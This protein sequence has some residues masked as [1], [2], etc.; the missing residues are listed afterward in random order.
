MNRSNLFVVS[1]LVAGL[2]VPALVMAGG[3]NEQPMPSQ[4][5]ATDA[6]K[7][8]AATSSAAGTELLGAGASFPYPIYSKMFDEYNKATGVKVNYQSIGSSGGVKNIK[9]KVVDFGASDAFLNDEAMKQFDAP[10]V[11]IPTVLGSIVVTYNLPGNPTLK[12]T[13]TVIADIFMGKITKWNEPAIARINSGVSLPATDII[14]AHRSDGSGT[15]NNFTAYLARVSSEWKDKIGT[16]NSVNWPVGLGGAQNTGVAGIVKSTPGA[17][18]YVELAYAIQNSLPYATVQNRAG[19]W[20]VPSLRSTS[21]AGDTQL[22]ADTRIVLANTDATNGYPISTMTWLVVYKEQ[23][24]GGRSM[25]RAGELVKLLWWVTHEGQQY[26]ESLD[27]AP[28]PAAAVKDVETILKSITFDG[29][30]IRQ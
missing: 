5:S 22:P 15:T 12:L 3:Q 4:M 1:A 9:D 2:I 23:N 27:Y 13:G 25:A 20:I 17:V 26:A 29:K 28:L 10:I 16:A 11:H 19:N 7:P 14:V 6:V 21:L 24:Y 30:P 18:G 8:A